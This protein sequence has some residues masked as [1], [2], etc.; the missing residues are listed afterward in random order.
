MSSS[1]FRIAFEGSIFD[2]GEMDVRDLAPALLALGEVVQA[3]N[4]V[5]NGDRAQAT[6]KMKATSRGSFVALLS[7]DVSIMTAITDLLD[8]VTANPERVTAANTLLDLLIKTGT[9]VVGGVGGSIGFFGLLKKLKG[10]RPT[11]VVE[12]PDGGAVIVQNHTHLHIDRQTFALLQDVKTRE[13][14]ENFGKRALTIK[15]VSRVRFEDT[16]GPAKVSLTKADMQSMQVPPATRDEVMVDTVDREV[17]LK[18]ITSA[19]RDG[20]KWRFSDGGEKPFLADVEDVEFA[21][22]VLEGKV[23]LSAN[24]TL[25]CLVREEQHLGPNGLAKDIKVLKVLEH[26]AGAKQLKLL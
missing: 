6:L 24:D 12:Q 22:S 11:S 21:N 26:I 5:V 8:V 15:D 7:I 2:R 9:T 13:A 16:N 10:E 23:A 20:Y 18:I 25:R 19:F 3:A 4:R 17:W 14:V 1:S